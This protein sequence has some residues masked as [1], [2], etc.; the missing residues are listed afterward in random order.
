MMITITQQV[1]DAVTMMVGITAQASTLS[2]VHR[3]RTQTRVDADPMAALVELEDSARVLQAFMAFVY[4]PRRVRS[5]WSGSFKALKEEA[6]SL[7]VAASSSADRKIPIQYD[8]TTGSIQYLSDLATLYERVVGFLAG[9]GRDVI[10]VCVDHLRADLMRDAGD[11]RLKCGLINVL[12]LLSVHAA[13]AVP[14]LITAVRKDKGGETS[15]FAARALGAIGAGTAVSVLTQVCEKKKWFPFFRK[16]ETKYWYPGDLRAAAAEALERIRSHRA[17][18]LRAGRATPEAASVL[19]SVR[20][21]HCSAQLKAPARSLGKKAACKKCGKTLM[22]QEIPSTREAPAVPQSQSDATTVAS[23]GSVFIS[24]A[25]AMAELRKSA[26]Q[27]TALVAEGE[28]RAYRDGDR[29]AM[30]FRKDDIASMSRVLEQDAQA[31]AR[32]ANKSTDA[33]PTSGQAA[34]PDKRLTSEEHK[35]MILRLADENSQLGH[36]LIAL[37][38]TDGGFGNV[39]RIRQIG[40][41]VHRLGG[42]DLMQCFYYGVRNSGRYFSQDIWDGIGSWRK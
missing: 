20:C 30:K 1:N 26:E 28:V 10:P 27:L 4:A 21:P 33:S 14:C 32:S 22:I 38:G 5:P 11:T 6:Q 39:A 12:E 36:E 17:A 15:V 24:F 3:L 34:R 7:L 31:S 2:T 41:R 9:L 35:A 13:E 25:E 8:G 19:V 18:P 23:D 42:M 16:G 29:N 37:V 40:E